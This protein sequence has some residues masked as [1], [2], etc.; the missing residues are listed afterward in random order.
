MTA[1][2]LAAVL[3]SLLAIERWER[4]RLERRHAAAMDRH[5]ETLLRI[6]INRTAP[7]PE[8]IPTAPRE[9]V[10]LQDPSA[11]AQTRAYRAT[12]ERGADRIIEEEERAGR[13]IDRAEA[14]AI[15]EELVSQ[16]PGF[17]A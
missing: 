10:Q 11:L 12:I 13:N 16:M 8:P 9:D 5:A 3:A 14:L 2:L 17:G 15:A 4:W 6:V 7:A 1:Y